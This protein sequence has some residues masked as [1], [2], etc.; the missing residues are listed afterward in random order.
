MEILE[1]FTCNLRVWKYIKTGNYSISFLDCFS[2]V[3]YSPIVLILQYSRS[4][5]RFPPTL[6]YCLVLGDVKSIG[7]RL[8]HF[9]L[10]V[11]FFY[12]IP[13]LIWYHSVINPWRKNYNEGNIH[14]IFRYACC[15][16]IIAYFWLYCKRIEQEDLVYSHLLSG[17]GHIRSFGGIQMKS[18][19]SCLGHNF[20]L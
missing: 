1:A 14:L 8:L 11:V 16:V 6:L 17:T 9:I 19:E 5:I 10:Y 2:A 4:L 3:Y 18:N 13:S 7:C 15:Y 20:A 12:L